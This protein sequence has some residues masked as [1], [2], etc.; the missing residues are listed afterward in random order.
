MTERHRIRVAIV[1]AGPAGISAG[2]WAKRM[3]LDPVVVEAADP[4]GQLR[5]AQNRIVDYPGWPDVAASELAAH[6]ID[7]LRRTGVRL[8]TAAA[9]VRVDTAARRVAS[10]VGIWEVDALILATGARERR[11]GIPGEHA[12]YARGEVWSASRD[13][14]RFRGLPVAVIGGGDRALEGAWLLAEA[15]AQVTL[16]H[17][18]TSFRAR[19]QWRERAL[20][21]PGISVI[22]PAVATRIEGEKQTRAVHLRSA[23]GREYRVPAAAVLVRIG[24]EPNLDGIE[25]LPTR[26]DHGVVAVD[27][28]GRTSLP[29]VYAAGDVCTPAPYTSVASAVADGMRAV[30]AVIMDWECGCGI[31]RHD[32]DK[33]L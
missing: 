31:L 14:G 30:K 1:G 10:P 29:G 15:G 5:R 27:R 8:A 13:A 22:A 28:W 16:V 32:H 17:R 11:L 6:L 24:T 3:G 7:H 12:M 20:R 21:H 23:D 25:G 9:P 33:P 4:G 19:K 2:I 18:R 26:E